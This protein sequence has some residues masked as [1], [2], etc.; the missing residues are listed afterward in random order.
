MSAPAAPA[1]TAGSRPLGRLDAFSVPWPVL[2][3]AGLMAATLLLLSAAYGFHRD[4]MYF[5][6]AGRHPAFGYADQPPITPLLS[7]ASVAL[8]GVS[9]TAVRLL[10][11]L[12]MA[13]VVIV[14]AL[15]ARDLGGPRRAQLLAA[16]TAALS[17]YLGAGHLD[18]TAEFDLLAW[19]V[20]V[21]LLV[22]ILAGG[23]PRLWVVLGVVAGI[24]LE[25]K[26]TLFFLGAGLALGLLPAR[27]WDVIRSPW[28]WAA[29]GIALLIAM[30]NLIWE[31]ANGFPQLALASH[32]AAQAGDNR[33]QTLPLLWLFSGP[34]LFPITVAGLVWVL[35]AKEAG[36]WRTIGIAAI[37]GPALIFVMGGKPYY[38]IGTVPMFMAAGGMA[39]DRWLAR[40]GRIVMGVK[41]TGFVSAAALSG[42]LVA[43]LTLPILPLSD[44]SKTSLPTTVT[45]TAEQVGWPEYVSQVEGVV[46]SLPADERARTAIVTSNYGE[47]AALELLGT[48]LPP[49]YSG[50]NAYWNWGPPP[51]GL[52]VVVL[53]GDSFLTT[54]GQY[55]T[56]CHT[57]AT[58]HNALSIPNQEEGQ[59]IQVC[60]GLQA[61]WAGIWPNLRHLD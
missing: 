30:P 25:N 43:Y 51:S 61:S 60:T 10:P 39:L 20:A 47:A 54:G 50:H 24:G 21:W 7:A 26:D 52:D 58:I 23:D 41:W 19:A 12:E 17:G 38:A 37:A 15:I 46:A 56:G 55:F 11:A 22:R 59:A 53:V 32:I 8:L 9:P 4:E 13:L 48:G 28:A 34:F 29:I 31:A 49:V 42:L 44:Y 36:P 27:R 18:D 45:D 2:A 6:V 35:R 16:V 1:P 5:I 33:A 40:G 57:V 14:T 3:V